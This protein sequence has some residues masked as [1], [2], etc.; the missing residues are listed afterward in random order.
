[1][2]EFVFFLNCNVDSFLL[3]PETVLHPQADLSNVKSVWPPLLKQLLCNPLNEMTFVVGAGVSVSSGLPLFRGSTTDV[4]RKDMFRFS[5]VTKHFNNSS[6]VQCYR[7]LIIQCR[8]AQPTFFHNMVRKLCINKRCSTIVTQNVDMLELSAFISPKCIIHLHG[9]LGFLRCLRCG[10]RVRPL[11]E[12]DLQ[13]MISQFPTDNCEKC[14]IT[15]SILVPDIIYYDDFNSLASSWC[16]NDGRLL[17]VVSK[18]K[19]NSLIFVVGTSLSTPDAKRFLQD[20][21]KKNV[22]LFGVM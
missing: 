11:S 19:S 7:N 2:K 12:E 3:N 9:V 5:E 8:D 10:S 17:D 16:E 13:T 15:T 18:L 14:K 6:F 1:M 22:S 4:L 20:C 21:K